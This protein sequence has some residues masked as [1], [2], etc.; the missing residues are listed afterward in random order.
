MLAPLGG[1]S[2]GPLGAQLSAHHPI[3][4][5]GTGMAPHPHSA[6]VGAPFLPGARLPVGSPDDLRFS[7]SQDFPLPS[8]NLGLPQCQ[9]QCHRPGREGDFHP[10]PRLPGRLR[11]IPST[12]SPGPALQHPFPGL[13]ARPLP[14]QRPLQDLE[15]TDF[16][17]FLAGG[18]DP[19][20]LC[21]LGLLEGSLPFVPKRQRAPVFP[22]EALRQAWEGEEGRD[23]VLAPAIP[24]RT[25]S[26]HVQ[27]RRVTTDPRL[28]W[29][30]SQSCAMSRVRLSGGGAE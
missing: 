9:P 1:T 25:F 10:P 26:R 24:N 17:S 27:L 18:G 8:G 20:P 4:A 7:T 28:F 5:G 13:R 16:S 11:R 19:T 12:P 23:S 14:P 6:I 2:K 21:P 30:R 3:L 22:V 29:K 15:G